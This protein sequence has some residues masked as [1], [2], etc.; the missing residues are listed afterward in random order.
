MRLASS[1]QSKDSGHVHNEMARDGR[2]KGASF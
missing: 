1:E 2:R